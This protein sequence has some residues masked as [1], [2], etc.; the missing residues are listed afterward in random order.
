MPPDEPTTPAPAEAP[1]APAK[2]EASP[3][4]ML[5]ILGYYVDK[6]AQTEVP[7]PDAGE[8]TTPADPAPGAEP[9]PEAAAP[10]AEAEPATP[11]GEAAPPAE[12]AAEAP[13]VTTPPTE[14]AKKV[15][16]DEPKAVTRE[17][18]DEAIREATTK[19]PDPGTADDPLAKYGKLLPQERRSL[20]LAQFAAKALPDV[21]ADMEK[22]EI[23][24]IAKHRTFIAENTDTDGKFDHTTEEYQDFLRKN[25][26]TYRPGDREE[27]MLTRAEER[28]AQKAQ[29]KLMPQLEAYRRKLNEVQVTPLVRDT[30]KAVE[31]DVLS[32]LD[33]PI[34]EAM[35]ANPSA[36]LKSYGVEAP[37]ATIIM[38]DTKENVRQ[39]MLIANGVIEFNPDNGIHKTVANFVKRQGE[40][41]DAM[42]EDKRM[43]DGK[44]LVS[45]KK[46]NETPEHK[47]TGI[48]TFTTMDVVDML[49]ASGKNYLTATIKAE[50]AKL[51]ASG[52]KKVAATQAAPAAKPAAAATSPAAAPAKPAAAAAPKA[53]TPPPPKGGSQPAP[54]A[55][56]GAKGAAKPPAN[57]VLAALGYDKV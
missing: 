26:P 5:K 44:L 56:V 43:R 40:L 20:E 25:R 37:V 12:P 39:Y 21:Y 46:F 9:D 6:K 53:A 50:H 3:D 24:F 38:E 15:R 57:P 31:D 17:E 33:K 22:R 19:K 52:Y 41:L 29:E 34:A 13:P 2:A 11:E 45:V 55:T 35:K 54:G 51:E 7:D 48:R 18:L 14:R 47:R 1:A 49:A 16:P 32:A 27:L 10:A 42:P 4:N 30:L 36:A 8:A 23:D 28:G